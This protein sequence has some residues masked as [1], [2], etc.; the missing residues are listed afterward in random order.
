MKYPAMDTLTNHI[1]KGVYGDDLNLLEVIGEFQTLLHKCGEYEAALEA[2]REACCHEPTSYV[3]KI[4][5]LADE[6][7]AKTVLSNNK[8]PEGK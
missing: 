7:L 5:L 1:R 3:Y 2:I 8:Q 6:A 4:V